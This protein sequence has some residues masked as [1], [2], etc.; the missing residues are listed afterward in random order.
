[1]GWHRRPRFRHYYTTQFSKFGVSLSSLFMSLSRFLLH[2]RQKTQQIGIRWDRS[3]VC[4]AWRGIRGWSRSETKRQR[5]ARRR[6]A[7][8]PRKTRWNSRFRSR[9]HWLLFDLL[10]FH[11]SLLTNAT[12]TTHWIQNPVLPLRRELATRRFT[13]EHIENTIQRG[14]RLVHLRNIQR[15]HEYLH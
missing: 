14:S 1:M 13:A 4:G 5:R 12:P 9:F 6:R 3:R 7:K 11:D 15:N 2:F 10:L 8:I